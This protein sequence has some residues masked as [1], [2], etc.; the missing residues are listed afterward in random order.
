MT[1]LPAPLRGLIDAGADAIA[2]AIA[3]VQ[4]EAARAEE[5][6]QA[7]H[8][9]FMAEQREALTVLSRTAE[10][11]IASVRDG[12]DGKDGER[13]P[14]GPQGERG[15]K[16]D[17]GEQGPIGPAGQD[18]LAGAVGAQGEAGPQGERG[19][20]GETGPAGRDG[21]DGLPGL[22]GEQGL[23][24][25]PGEQGPA[26][27]RGEPGIAGESGRDGLSGEDV[28]VERVD[29]RTIKLVFAGRDDTAYAFELSFP[30]VIN[31]GVYEQGRA[32]D[33]GDAVTHEGSFWIAQ[34]T[35]DSVPAEGS[36]WRL[37]VARGADGRDGANG[38]DG[39]P[40]NDA[41]P[42]EA[43][44]LFDPAAIYRKNDT[45]GF[46][47][48][49]WRAKRDDPGELP[50]DGWMLS[51]SRGKRG[52]RGERGEAGREGLSGKDGASVAAAY[53][54]TKGMELTLT[55]DDGVEVKADLYDL[56]QTIRG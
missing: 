24:G 29:E 26:G 2:R 7:E 4:R 38:V 30:V 44:G 23:A 32:Y 43:R 25:E 11:K 21:V 56:A 8:R 45:V 54:D 1:E 55:R 40:G 16:G 20:V 33:D 6:R 36:A 48:S 13:G 22:Q 3:G 9:A 5:L 49:E 34:R 27:E 17:P 18:G 19:E 52:D 53:V 50:G 47:G 51:A 37:A 12:V 42:G 10:E 46:N 41:Y 39:Q 28:D 31:R 14:V 15:E 35:T